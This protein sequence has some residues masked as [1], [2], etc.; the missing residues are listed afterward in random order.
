M[1][2]VTLYWVQEA[3]GQRAVTECGGPLLYQL[4]RQRLPEGA[5]RL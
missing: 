1:H 2:S 3:E 4:P 5:L